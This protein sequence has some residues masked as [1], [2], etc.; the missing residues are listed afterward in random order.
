MGNG[1]TAKEIGDKV[2]NPSAP[3][4]P[5]T[6]KAKQAAD[7]SALLTIEE[8]DAAHPEVDLFFKAQARGAKQ[9]ARGKQMTDAQYLSAID[10]VK[11]HVMHASLPPHL[12]HKPLPKPRRRR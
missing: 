11:G 10:E 7:P 8:L 6:P 2:V 5:E 4:P 3:T 1:I 12:A 9:W